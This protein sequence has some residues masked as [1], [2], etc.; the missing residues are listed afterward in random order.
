M[1]PTFRQQ[2]E[3]QEQD[4]TQIE[5]TPHE[6]Q[7]KDKEQK[8][9]E[10]V[11]KFYESLKQINP[12]FHP[13]FDEL[14]VWRST[15]GRF[16]CSSIVEPEQ[17]FI[18]RPI[19]RQEWKEFV[20]LYGNAED[21]ERQE[22]LLKKCLLYPPVEVVTDKCPAGYLPAMETKIMY[23]SGFVSDGQLLNSIKVIK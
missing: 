13:S 10:I 15:Y 6:Q 3:Y 8:E 2:E 19:Y 16:Y 22:G 18:W 1:K 14:K 5:L 12:V 23:Q 4:E 17:I 7:L 20:S 11:S 9:L 21:A